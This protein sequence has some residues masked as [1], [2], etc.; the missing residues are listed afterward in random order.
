MAE[1]A[2]DS[3]M[4]ALGQGAITRENEWRRANGLPEV[5][6]PEDGRKPLPLVD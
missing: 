6:L 3:L 5:A 1:G 2:E 4:K